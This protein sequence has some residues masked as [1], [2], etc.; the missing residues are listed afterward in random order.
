MVNNLMLSKEPH[1][2]KVGDEC[3]D[4]SLDL[5]LDRIDAQLVE[6]TKTIGKIIRFPFINICTFNNG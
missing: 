1:A 6:S 2:P 5:S 3:P 4:V